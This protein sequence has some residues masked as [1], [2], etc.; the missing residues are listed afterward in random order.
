MLIASKDSD[1]AEHNYWAKSSCLVNPPPTVHLLGVGTRIALR[2]TYK[3]VPWG[4]GAGHYL[5]AVYF[6]RNSR[7]R[8]IQ[9]VH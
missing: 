9:F 3:V 2:P 4:A 7:L 6:G 8:I 1:L 5:D